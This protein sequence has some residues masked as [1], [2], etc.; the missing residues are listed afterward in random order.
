MVLVYGSSSRIYLSRLEKRSQA[1][2]GRNLTRDIQAPLR[3][4]RVRPLMA[5]VTRGCFLEAHWT[6]DSCLRKSRSA[7]AMRV[8]T[9]VR[10]RFSRMN[11]NY[12]LSGAPGCIATEKKNPYSSA[13]IINL[14]FS[15]M[16][17]NSCEFSYHGV[18]E[19]SRFCKSAPTPNLP[20]RS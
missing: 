7:A 5:F 19:P 8:T 3:Q 17:P 2:R 12:A 1:P 14:R 13:L 11:R 9:Y 10:A 20:M 18:A 16:N 4:W 6:P 15:R